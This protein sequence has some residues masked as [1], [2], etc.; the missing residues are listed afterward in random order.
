MFKKIPLVGYF[1][2]AETNFHESTQAFLTEGPINFS[3]I[4]LTAS[5][6]VGFDED[7]LYDWKN[8]SWNQAA[9]V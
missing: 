8:I 2:V 1:W 6:D 5:K 4:N 9:D 7:Y 3:V